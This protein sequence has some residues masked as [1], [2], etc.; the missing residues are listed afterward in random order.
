[1]TDGEGKGAS[2]A[3]LYSLAISGTDLRL[4]AVWIPDTFAFSVTYTGDDIWLTKWSPVSDNVALI[5]PAGVTVVSGFTFAHT[6]M[7]SLTL[8]PS[9]KS[10]N[11]GEFHGSY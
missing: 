6:R 9:L 7:T 1:M 5:I 8:P 4:Y 11:Y 2:Y 3:P 10:I